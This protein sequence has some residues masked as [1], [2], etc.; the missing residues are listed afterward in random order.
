MKLLKNKNIIITGGNGFLGRHFCE[1]ISEHGGNPIIFDVNKKGIE[2]F[3]SKLKKKYHNKPLYLECDITDLKKVK[4]FKKILINKFKIIHALVNNAAIN[5]KFNKVDFKSNKKNNLDPSNLIEDFNVSIVGTL[6]CINVY[7][8]IFAKQKKGSIVNISSDLGI[9]SPNQ[10]LYNK[11]ER[12]EN[13]KPIS[14]SIIKTGIIGITKY[15]S[16]YWSKQNVRC[17]A[18]APGGVFES[19]DNKFV[20]KISKMVPLNRMAKPEELKEPLIFL[21]SDNSSYVNGH[22]LVADGGRTIW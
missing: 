9:I 13:V 1:A 20:T 4:K 8:P 17:N 11:S 6:N 15:I 22:T 3:L 18:L 7:G 5:P 16:T 10:S 14:Y 12:I 21:L 19:Q 2:A